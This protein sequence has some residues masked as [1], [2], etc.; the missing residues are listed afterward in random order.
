MCRSWRPVVSRFASKKKVT[1]NFW[2]VSDLERMGWGAEGAVCHERR[3]KGRK[4][5]EAINGRVSQNQVV[6][7]NRRG[8]AARQ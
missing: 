7:T 3:W 6:N 1:V 8:L 4:W 5:K 2:K